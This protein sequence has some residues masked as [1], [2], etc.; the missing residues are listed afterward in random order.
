M[1]PYNYVITW[2][3]VKDNTDSTPQ[4]EILAHGVFIAKDQLSAYKQMVDMV[5]IDMALEAEQ[6]EF[7][8]KPFIES[9]SCNTKKEIGGNML[10]NFYL[11][12][13]MYELRT[14]TASLEDFMK[15]TFLNYTNDSKEP[16]L[17]QAMMMIDVLGL[18]NDDKK[19]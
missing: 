9:K 18:L 15:G 17:P 7:M 4:P 13:S 19:L 6:I 12:N 8:A 10:Y 2:Y 16:E 3:P 14:S 5:S 11:N 1:E